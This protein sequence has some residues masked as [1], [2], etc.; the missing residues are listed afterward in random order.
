MWRAAAHAASLLNPL[1]ISCESLLTRRKA[2]AFAALR[3]ARRRAVGFTRMWPFWARTAA[4][5]AALTLRHG[6]SK[7][8]RFEAWNQKRGNVLDLGCKRR[9]LTQPDAGDE[10]AAAQAEAEAD[11]AAPS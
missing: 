10:A 9:H 4:C 11:C 8:Q 5:H 6:K 3:S 7:G 2:G 1:G